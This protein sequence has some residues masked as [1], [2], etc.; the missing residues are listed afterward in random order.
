MLAVTIL[1]GL[2]ACQRPVISGT[3]SDHEGN[4][5]AAVKV[6]VVGTTLSALADDKGHYT[7]PYVPGAVRIAVTKD[8]Y[9]PVTRAYDIAEATTFPAA[10]ISL[11]PYAPGAA[12]SWLN[13]GKAE[14]LAG[15]SLTRNGD[16][17]VSGLPELPTVQL[18]ADVWGF[19]YV[20]QGDE[21]GDTDMAALLAGLNAR[22]G[23]DPGA[24]LYR[25]TWKESEVVSGGYYYRRSVVPVRMWVGDKRVD[26]V[27][28]PSDPLTPAGWI[29]RPKASL[30]DGVYTLSVRG[31]KTTWPFVVGTVAPP[32]VAE[33]EY[34]GE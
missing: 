18:P 1:L 6:E 11:F 19:V 33:E 24:E 13:E 26:A 8:G 22:G 2:S 27:V 10:P 29:I 34:E 30:E 31:S 17:G 12:F 3:V 23:G 14:A 21:S 16:A 20:S 28:K 15:V 25:M 9:L 32:V 5:S 4:P 7:V